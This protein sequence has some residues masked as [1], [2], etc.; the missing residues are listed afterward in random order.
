ML[1]EGE[2]K[3]LLPTQKDPEVPDFDVVGTLKRT[4]Y[5]GFIAFGGPAAHVGLL[6]KLFVRDPQLS[7]EENARRMDKA[8]FLELNA[9]CV[10]LPGPSSTQ[11]VCAIAMYYGGW[12]AGVLSF[13]LWNLP[14]A[15]LVTLIG[16]R[17]GE[18]L[19][20]GT[21]MWLYGAK[22]AASSLVFLAAYGFIFKTC[23]KKDGSTNRLN[24]LVLAVSSCA[25]LLCN[26][27]DVQARDPY[28][29]MWVYPSLLVGGGVLTLAFGDTPSVS[30]E[31][32]RISQRIAA[33]SVPRWVGG[34]II[35]AVLALLA[36]CFIIPPS[37]HAIEGCDAGCRAWN[38]FN[39]F[40]R[41]GST[42]YGGGQVVVPM[43]LTYVVD[44]GWVTV[45]QFYQGLALIGMMP[46]PMFNF[47]AYIGAVYGA[48]EP[49]GSQAGA[50]YSTALAWVGLFGPGLVLIFGIVPFWA[51]ARE[52]ATFRGIM[53]G[54]N[55]AAV[56]LI[57]GSCFVL[58][59]QTVTAPAC[60]ITFA[61]TVCANTFMPW[62]A[63][64]A[65]Y[66][67][68]VSILIGAAFAAV[69]T[70]NDIGVGLYA[71]QYV[72]KSTGV[73]TPQAQGDTYHYCPVS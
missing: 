20:G 26:D 13:F 3:P 59:E 22:A 7:E 42:V 63:K 49:G 55:A 11:L 70:M 15:L 4:W 38:I 34:I 46:G 50:W 16:S 41:M 53:P 52:S 12:V 44:P 40:W 62:P 32:L 60:A 66:R 17:I 68:P 23:L 31:E 2:E 29:T 67:G 37:E 65:N 71:S 39:A 21:P 10:A 24:S 33:M 25:V 14:A 69:L 57:V 8:T 43:T 72:C 1:E 45:D 27:A 6:D 36:M 19:H 61:L 9:M 47:A 64:L 5:L 28:L 54:V 30:D 51:L 18:W 56:G 48:A 35:V 58:F 73:I